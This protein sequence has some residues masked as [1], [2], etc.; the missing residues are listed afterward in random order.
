M[1]LFQIQTLVNDFSD[2]DKEYLII[3]KSFIS[4]PRW[5]GFVP[6]L[7]DMYKSL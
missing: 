4:D 3:F 6:A 1:L 7:P 5:R 2:C